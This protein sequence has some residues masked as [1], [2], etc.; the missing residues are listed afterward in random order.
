M[1]VVGQV[2]FVIE[3]LV[4]GVERPHPEAL[5]AAAAILALWT[6]V[7][8]ASRLALGGLA[9]VAVGLGAR[10]NREQ[11]ASQPVAQ[12]HGKR[13]EGRQRR[14]QR[15]AKSSSRYSS[16]RRLSE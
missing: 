11:A 8:L 6:D 10:R 1:P 15:A 2:S 4:V 3:P 14:E 7:S 13:R 9:A 5:A 12:K 16:V